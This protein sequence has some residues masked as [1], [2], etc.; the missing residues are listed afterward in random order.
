LLLE[1][2]LAHIENKPTIFC[3][4]SFTRY[5]NFKPGRIVNRQLILIVDILAQSVNGDDHPE[6]IVLDPQYDASEFS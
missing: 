3:F 6:T 4:D 5:A 2:S 1:K